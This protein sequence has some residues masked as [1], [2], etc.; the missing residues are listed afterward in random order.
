M[1]KKNLNSPLAIVVSADFCVIAA[2][3][4]RL[5]IQ[6]EIVD[7]SL[8]VANIVYLPLQTPLQ[9]PNNDLAK[10]LTYQCAEYFHNP[11][12]IFDLP[13][14]PVGTIH[15]QK[16]WATVAQI[17]VGLT[18]TYGEIAKKI[19]SGPRAVGSACGANYYPLVIPCHRVVA[20]S[21]LGGFMQEDAPGFYR[22]IK[23]WLLRH[24]GAILV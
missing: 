16:V 6:T 10:Q 5:G 15:Q 13:L 9:R 21:S 2:P 20:A 1:P 11:E 23:R 12:F 17:P 3:F 4:G 19:K 18:S 8:M 14:K 7:G 24:E 22:Q